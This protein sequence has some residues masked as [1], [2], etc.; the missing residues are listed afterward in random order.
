MTSTA[1]M[2][3]ATDVAVRRVG[4]NSEKLFDNNS[5]ELNICH[6]IIIIFTK[7]VYQSDIL[8]C[9]EGVFDAPHNSYVTIHQ[10]FFQQN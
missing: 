9:T 1:S 10:L 4:P 2:L 5:P 3:Y 6:N 7:K 8:M